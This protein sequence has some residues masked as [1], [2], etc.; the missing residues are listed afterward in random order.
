MSVRILVLF[1]KFA[2]HCASS[3]CFYMHI[4]MNNGLFARWTMC[5]ACVTD[6]LHVSLAVL[7]SSP[8][9]VS[10]AKAS[11]PAPYLLAHRF[12]RSHSRK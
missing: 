11:L 12:F 5:G 10:D 6:N 1:S 8:I 3:V 9:R 2:L 4:C 7:R